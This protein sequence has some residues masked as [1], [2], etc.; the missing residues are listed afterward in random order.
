MAGD[1]DIETY[2]DLKFNLEYEWQLDIELAGQIVFEHDQKAD[3]NKPRCETEGDS[4]EERPKK[5]TDG[6]PYY[7]VRRIDEEKKK[8]KEAQGRNA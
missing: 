7:R 8:R 1:T 4:K 2:D 5:P 6:S 3:P